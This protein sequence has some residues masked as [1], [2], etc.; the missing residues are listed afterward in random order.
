MLIYGIAFGVALAVA[1]VALVVALQRQ[2]PSDGLV[3]AFNAL[4]NDFANLEDH[5]RSALARISR[6]KRATMNGEVPTTGVEEATEAP[7][8]L[9]LFP[10]LTAR[11]A[12]IHSQIIN[13]RNK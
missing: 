11:Q 9:S 1:S 2:K 5:V 13:R 3:R 8:P 6:L 10:G 4:E 12:A 7:A